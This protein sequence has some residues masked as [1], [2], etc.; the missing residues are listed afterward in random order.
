MY[1]R[2][3]IPLI[4]ILLTVLIV[5]CYYA[6]MSFRTHSQKVEQEGVQ[7]EG[8]QV[9]TPKLEDVP[10]EVPGVPGSAPDAVGT[11]APAAPVVLE[12]APAAPASATAAPVDV[13][14]SPITPAV[15][16][17]PVA[18]APAP[19]AA[20]VA[21]VPTPAVPAPVA[22]AV[23][24]AVPAPAAPAVVASAD[25]ASQLQKAK[26]LLAAKKYL[27]ARQ[28]VWDVLKRSEV[29]EYDATWFAAAGIANEI[30]HA[31][32]YGRVDA[33]EKKVYTV[34]S[35]DALARIAYRQKTTVQGMMVLNNLK[36]AGRIF[37]GQKLMYLSGKLEI[38]VSK[39]KFTLVLL[40]DGNVYRIFKVGIGKDNR[41]PVGIF[42]I[43]D[44]VI[45]PSWDSPNEGR[46]PPGDPRNILGT[47]WMGLRAIEGTNESLI[48]YGIHGTTL[49]E[50]VGTPS[51]A[52]CVRLKNEDVNDLYTFIPEPGA[53]KVR[54]IIVE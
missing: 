15:A 32:Q 53:A 24:P 44:K 6:V 45:D 41:T 22:P 10:P 31:V 3:K 26:E 50:T 52:G 28:I 2:Y 51:S 54:V 27:E 5:L 46:I 34:K 4:I 48:G 42:E 36:N 18:A 43:K 13:P 49:P 12:P 47:R 19:A 30:N 1:L 40:L 16:A 21:P 29:K 7:A 17:V 20:T 8:V 14:A 39:S 37:P 23:T 25:C 35:G 9:D 38:H 11:P 33:P